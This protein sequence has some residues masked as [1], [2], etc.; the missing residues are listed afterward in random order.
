MNIPVSDFDDF[1][2]FTENIFLS[3]LNDKQQNE[4]IKHGIASLSSLI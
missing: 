4:L 1:D 3:K 2:L